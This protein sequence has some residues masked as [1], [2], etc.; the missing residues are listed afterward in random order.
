MKNSIVLNTLIAFIV[1]STVLVSCGSD[2]HQDG[3]STEQHDLNADH[4]HETMASTF[5]CSM[6]PDITGKEGDKCS[7]CNMALVASSDSEGELDDGTTGDP[8]SCP[9]HPEVTGEKGDKCS[10]CNMD[11]TLAEASDEDKGD[12]Q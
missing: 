2:N 9:M 1:G 10:K 11:L 4:S 6:H 5:V 8:H 12:L 3:D 7:K